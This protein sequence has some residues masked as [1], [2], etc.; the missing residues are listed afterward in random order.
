M[1]AK[2][3]RGGMAPECRREG[4]VHSR[5]IRSEQ[6]AYFAAV[7]ISLLV[8]ATA[9]AQDVGFDPSMTAEEFRRF[10]TLVAQGIYPTPVAPATAEGLF[11]FDIGVAAT[12]IE[13]DEDAAYW[14][15][16]GASDL[17]VSG[18]FPIPRVVVSK[19]I[20][21]A[22]VSA[23]WA[24]IPDSDITVL[25]G[26]V[27]VPII[28]GDIVT[29]T[30][31]LRGAYSTLRGV[32]ELDLKT[33]GLEL[34]VSKGFG[35]VTPYIGAG[36]ARSESEGRIVVPGFEETLVSNTEKARYTAG[37]QI[38]LL[39]PKIVVEVTEGDVRSWSAKFSFGF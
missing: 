21:F 5:G 30:V 25:G 17:T 3:T 19:G 28:R 22:N 13:V 29:P 1:G 15:L 8:S 9:V 20:V 7:L 24:R 12:G 33:Y 23:S 32:D 14:R 27:D 10:S 37:L 26:A 2:R 18:Y 16:A 39:I 35:P 36:I 31:A 38:S 11:G 6:R 34:F 4:G